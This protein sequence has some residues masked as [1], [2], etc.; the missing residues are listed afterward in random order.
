MGLKDIFTTQK[1]VEIRHDIPKN[2]P[3]DSTAVLSF[4]AKGTKDAG[5]CGG[6]SAALLPGLHAV[7]MQLVRYIQDDEKK[8]NERKNKIRQE[9]KGLEAKKI[10]YETEIKKEQDKLTHEENKIVNIIKEIDNIKENPK[11][12]SGDSFVKASFWIG[13]IIILFLTVYLF[14]FYSS[15]AYSAFFKDFT[16][17][18]TKITQAIFDAQAVGKAWTDGF[19]ELVFILAIPAVF[20]GLGFLIYKF[21]EEKENSKYFKITGLMLVTF[22]F[23]FIIA[24]AIVKE[25]YNIARANELTKTLPP[26]DIKMAVQEVNFWIIIFAGFVVYIIWGLVFSF[27]MSEYEKMDKVRYEI[28][29]KEQKLA[30]CKTECKGFR[31]KISTLDKEIINT[32]GEIDKLK[33]QLE[34]DVLYFNDVREGINN[35]FSGWVGYLKSTSSTQNHIDECEHIKDNF[36]SELKNSDFIRTDDK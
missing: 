18:D 16:P 6:S 12:V 8:Q 32:Q 11:I 26:M 28:K 7:Y 36:L 15:A 29:N 27:T 2:T 25:I 13:L 10:N 17:D 19:T 9:V 22:I 30:E 34:S 24:Y 21:S 4:T 3:K 33:I 20:L 23:D 35:Y 31:D 14:V 1:S 5:F